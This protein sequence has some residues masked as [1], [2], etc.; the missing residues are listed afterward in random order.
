MVKIG[1]SNTISVKYSTIKVYGKESNR[2]KT[3]LN[4]LVLAGK[5]VV[6]LDDIS[7]RI[8]PGSDEVLGTEA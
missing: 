2:T 6:L 1:T 7:S 8:E 5:S 4:K 3:S